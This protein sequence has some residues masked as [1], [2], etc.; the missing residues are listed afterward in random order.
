[1]QKWQATGTLNYGWIWIPNGG[2]G[3]R[4]QVPGALPSFGSSVPDVWFTEFNNS[5]IAPVTLDGGSALNFRNSG[6][7]TQWVRRPEEG[8]SYQAPKDGDRARA[9]M[10]GEYTLDNGQG[11]M[12]IGLFQTNFTVRLPFSS[13]FTWM[14][15]DITK[16]TASDPISITWSGADPARDFV[17]VRGRYSGASQYNFTCTESAAKGSFVVPSSIPLRG[18]APGL[19]L[20]VCVQSLS[21]N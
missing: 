17:L 13:S 16:V 6:G 3:F 9:L 2:A 10:P 18:H 7:T 11:G 5:G 14:N 21:P 1:M 12:D 19:N 15:R 20:S 4:R 8:D